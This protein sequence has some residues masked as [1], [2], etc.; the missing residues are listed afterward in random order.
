MELICSGFDMKFE[1][2]KIICVRVS[3]FVMGIFKVCV[4]GVIFWIK[5]PSLYGTIDTRTGSVDEFQ[6]QYCTIYILV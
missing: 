4:I 3:G 6:D 1:Q 5:V 2:S